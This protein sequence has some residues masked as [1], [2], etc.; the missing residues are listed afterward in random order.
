MS[1]TIKEEIH[2]EDIGTIFRLTVKDSDVVVDISSQTLMQIK[3]RPKDGATKTKTAV[4][5]T[6]GT[7]GKMQYVTIAG[8]L[9]CT[10]EWELQSRV[11]LSDGDWNSN[12]ATFRVYANL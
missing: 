3:L 10:D 6:D 4:F 11:T 5:T 7:D 8:D 9:H 2:K 12:I 1:T